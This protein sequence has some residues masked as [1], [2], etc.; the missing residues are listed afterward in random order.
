MAEYERVCES[1]RAHAG[2]VDLSTL[3]LVNF[4][5]AGGGAAGDTLED[6]PRRDPN[7]DPGGEL[8]R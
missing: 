4:L 7:Q 2:L 6:E 1:V 5:L 8:D 3:S